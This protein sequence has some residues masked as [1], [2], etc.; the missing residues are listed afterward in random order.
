MCY[1]IVNV[2]YKNAPAKA[3]DGSNAEIKNGIEEVRFDCETEV[4]LSAKLESIRDEESAVSYTVFLRHS[5][6]ERVAEWV[7]V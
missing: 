6:S 4:E 2:K 3:D 7:N 5:K 1:A